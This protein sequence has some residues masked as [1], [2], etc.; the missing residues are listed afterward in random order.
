MS[1]CYVLIGQP[2]TCQRG[3]ECFGGEATLS[4]GLGLGW[5]TFFKSKDWELSPSLSL[6]DP[7]RGKSVIGTVIYIDA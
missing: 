5:W 2:V 6:A 4:L 1:Q 7:L 3:G